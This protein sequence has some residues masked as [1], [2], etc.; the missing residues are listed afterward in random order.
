[1]CT[2]SGISAVGRGRSYTNDTSVADDKAMLVCMHNTAMQSA[3]HQVQVTDFERTIRLHSLL[4]DDDSRP[5]AVGCRIL[6]TPVFVD[7]R[8]TVASVFI[9]VGKLLLVA[10]NRL[11][12]AGRSLIDRIKDGNAE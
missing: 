1:M 7:D 5:G 6:T 2:V 3:R 8:E 4:T 10:S 12:G 11:G 9:D